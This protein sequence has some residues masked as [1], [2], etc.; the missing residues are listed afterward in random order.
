VVG[1]DNQVALTQAERRKTVD[2]I[3]KLLGMVDDGHIA[4]DAPTDAWSHSH[5]GN[6]DHGHPE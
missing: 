2:L 6:H 5:H 3:Q 1:H 4:A